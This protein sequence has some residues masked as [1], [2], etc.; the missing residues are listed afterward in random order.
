MLLQDTHIRQSAEP[1]PRPSMQ[2]LF[3]KTQEHSA[4]PSSQMPPLTPLTSSSR[5]CPAGLSPLQPRRSIGAAVRRL[6][7]ASVVG[8]RHLTPELREYLT[9]PA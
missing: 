5:R 1:A 7:R 8:L 2:P 6:R 3:A 4:L 9:I